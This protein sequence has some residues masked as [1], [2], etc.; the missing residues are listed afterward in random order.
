MEV[1]NQKGWGLTIEKKWT[2]T[3]FV[4]VHDPIYFGVYVD[5]ALQEGSVRRLDGTQTS[6]YYFFDELQAGKNFDHY[7]VREVVLEPS[8]GLVAD[9][10]GYVTGY[11]RVTPVGDGG[12]MTVHGLGYTATYEIGELTDHNENVRTDTVTNARPGIVLM[13]TDWNGEPL[14]GAVFTL[15]T[16]EGQDVAAASY[17]SNADGLITTAYLAPGDYLL[18]EIRAPK[19][20]VILDA[21]IALAVSADDEGNPQVSV[22]GIDACF[23]EV[24]HEDEDMI[25]AIRIRNR[26]SDLRALKVDGATGRPLSGASFALYRQVT[27]ALDGTTRMD[28][29]PMRGYEALVTEE[30]GVIPKITHD[31]PAGTYYLVETRAPQDYDPLTEPLCFTLGADGVVSVETEDCVDWLT[32]TDDL[33][34][35]NTSFTLSVLNGKTRRV[36][37]E[38][39]AAGTEIRLQGAAFG[40]YRA[41]DYDDDKKAP[42]AGATALRSGVTDENGWLSLGSVPMGEYRLVET[43]APAGYIGLDAP[44]TVYVDETVAAMQGASPSIVRYDE[45][46]ETWAIRVWNSTGYALPSTGGVGT[47]PFKAL[48]LAFIAG[49]LLALFRRRARREE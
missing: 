27:I 10:G 18:T 32:R 42:K 26:T 29:L 45:E 34:A 46:T 35:G 9:E 15:T 47:A 22:D 33:D 7:R 16:D 20:Y 24:R 43:A 8:D 41:V 31:L 40:L 2:D 4:P 37:I 44:I 36:A 1:R 25:A 14:A 23:F 38:K 13:K 6:L 30:D 21:P 3:D 12:S 5:D 49:A 17:T 19:G 48:G 39:T 11:T 28:Y